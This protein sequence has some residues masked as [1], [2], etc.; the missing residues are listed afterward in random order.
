M[1]ENPL[2]IGSVTTTIC[3]LMN[4]PAP[5]ICSA[6]IIDE[7]MK[8]AEGAR[9]LPTQRGLVFAVDA[10]G[11]HLLD[12]VPNS[13]ERLKEAAPISVGLRSVLPSVTPICFS[14]MFTG[15]PPQVHGVVKPERRLLECDTL[16]DAAL[17]AGIQVAIVAVTGSSIDLMF[18]GRDLDYFSESYDPA[19]VARTVGLIEEG[20]HDFIVSYVQ[21]YD[22]AHHNTTP[23]SSAAR[24]AMSN[25]IEDFE[26]IGEAVRA[27]WSSK[28]SFLWFA[29]DHGAHVDPE[30]GRGAHGSD[31][32]ED[33]DLLHFVGVYAGDAD[34]HER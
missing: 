30:T 26:R 21:Q 33:M 3:G 14:T 31:L 15:A 9:A 29:P 24:A 23:R 4:F 18:K 12:L 27:N 2:D 20:R 13:V 22:D 34:S 1:T 7:V 5:S 28:S 16:F 19:V 25:H 6:G 32:P 10:V 17:R 8:A 11:M